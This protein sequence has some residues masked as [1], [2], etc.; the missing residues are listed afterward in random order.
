MRDLPAVVVRLKGRPDPVELINLPM[1]DN[2]A[3][4]VLHCIA[5]YPDAYAFTA[6]GDQVVRFG[7]IVRVDCP[8]RGEILIDEAKRRPASG[9][10]F[11]PIQVFLSVR[12]G[13]RVGIANIPDSP[14]GRKLF[15]EILEQFRS[16]LGGRSGYTLF[17]TDYG[18][19]PVWE[20]AAANG[21]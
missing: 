11:R 6:D 7:D 21:S 15:R 19:I 2:G 13:E 10:I 16:V 3:D 1:R 20:L 8:E 5:A 4:M 17:T 14:E 9:E 18:H 12:N